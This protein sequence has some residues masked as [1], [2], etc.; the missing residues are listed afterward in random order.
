M[1]D[2]EREHSELLRRLGAECAV[3]LKSDGSFPLEAPCALALYGSGA[4]RTIKG[5]TG[6]GEVNSRYFVTAEEGL[7]AAGFK[8]TSKSWLD[9]YEEL[10]PEARKRFIRELKRSALKRG[11]LAILD[12]MGAVMPEPEYELPLDAGGDAAVYVLS[13]I[14]GEGSDRRPVPGDILPTKTEKRDI[15]ELNETYKRFLLVLNVGGAVDLSP[16]A[17][18]SNILLLSQLGVETG[19]ILADLILGKSVP[20]GKLSTSWSAWGDY[21]SVGEFGDRNDTRYKEGVYV[22]YR[23]FDAVGKKAL[24]PFGS[25]LSYTS[26]ALEAGAAAEENGI[27][28]LGVTVRNTGERRGKEVAQ[29]YVSP[30]QGRLDKPYQALA[31]FAKTGELQ[32]GQREELTL[33]FDLRELAS[34]DTER[35]AWIL[36]PGDYVLRL[37]VSGAD[38]KAAAALRLDGEVTVRRVKNCLGRPDFSDWKPERRKET[39]PAGL[40]VLSVSA[41]SFETET[42]KYE[43][44]EEIDPLVKTL[45]DEELCLLGIGA[46]QRKGSASVI[47]EAAQSVAGAAGETVTIKEKGIP[48]MVMADGPAGL[49]LSRR[50]TRDEKGV[51]AVDG[52]MPESV[53]ELMPAPAAFVMR[54]LDGKGGVKGEIREQNCSAIPIG[55]AI[56][57]SWNLAFAECCGDIVGDEMERFGVHLWLAP[58]LN[59]HRDI[60]CGRNF[61]Y[62]S[63][64]PLLSG[65]FAAAIT[66]GVQKHPG[67]GTTVKHFAANNQE[68][69]RYGS[70]SQVSERAMREIYLRGFEIAVKES[71]PHALMTSYNL[72]NGV[73]TS[74]CRDLIED[75]LRAEFGYRGIVMTDWI[76]GAMYGRKNKYPDPN[77]AR[78]AAAGG[79]LTMPGGMGDCKALMKGLKD[80][81]LT[82][83]QLQINATRVLRMAK[84]LT[85]KKAGGSI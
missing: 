18:V 8:I 84:R 61:E 78:T 7:E 76:I 79:D 74:E 6:S 59:I 22:G 30:P 32:P 14:S 46:F 57:Q 5:G 62:F 82:R 37:G 9:R 21:P 70:N 60:R 77:A 41:A 66:R 20:S 54:L 50:Y 27:V 13:R 73:H 48:G 63:E 52:G 55:T 33:S 51:H 17:E 44:N 29:L 45:S 1:N 12:S 34:Y 31:A 69:N 43:L 56:A 49:R 40:P 42:V 2:Y 75:I 28:R 58:A 47:G 53:M 71:Q 15:L 3:L 64:D 68:T 19:N 35:A 23:Y 85:E 26:F 67:C 38:T 25:G 83:R 10:Y 16:L 65:K 72:L 39:I 36:E 80:G 24:F 11:T 4:R 81:A